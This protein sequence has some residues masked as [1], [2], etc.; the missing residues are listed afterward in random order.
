M[1]LAIPLS[2]PARR[3]AAAATA[4]KLDSSAAGHRGDLV[5]DSLGGAAVDEEQLE[6]LQRLLGMQ[7][8]SVRQAG[9]SP[10]QQHLRQAVLDQLA[11]EVAAATDAATT[12]AQVAEPMLLRVRLVLHG[13]GPGTQ[14]H[15]AA[16]QR[17]QHAL[18]QQLMRALPTAL[19]VHVDSWSESQRGTPTTLAED[20]GAHAPPRPCWWAP[21][22]GL[23]SIAATV[24]GVAAIAAACVVA[25]LDSRRRRCA[26]APLWRWV[27]HQAQA[28]VYRRLAFDSLPAKSKAPQQP[29][30]IVVAAEEAEQFRKAADAA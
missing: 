16:E 29:M 28:S 14:A 5:A 10:H 13:W 20:A 22:G 26:A 4:A 30:L 19:L 27:D 25:A 7:Q 2:G 6:G 3:A 8:A 21:P 9:A 12:A 23:L 1:P 18:V 24:L 11:A 15:A 17:H